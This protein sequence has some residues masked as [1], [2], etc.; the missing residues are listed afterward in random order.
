MHKLSELMGQNERQAGSILFSFD[1]TIDGGD[2]SDI[3]AIQRILAKQIS[4]AEGLLPR[5]A[6]LGTFQV[7]DVDLIVEDDYDRLGSINCEL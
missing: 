7:E 3:E 2:A 6:T 5:C 1:V 4:A